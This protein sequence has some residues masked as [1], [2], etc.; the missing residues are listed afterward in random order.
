[1]FFKKGVPVKREEE[2][3]QFV[4]WKL[5]SF[6][7]KAIADKLSTEYY[8]KIKRNLNNITSLIVHFKEHKLNENNKE[9]P[10]KYS[11]HIRA[12]A[13]TKI[14][15]ASSFDWDLA[16]TLHK[17]YNELLHQTSRVMKTSD[18]RPKL[19]RPQNNRETRTGK[20]KPYRK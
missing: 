18:Q 7:E 13:P 15:E 17:V 6:Q 3:I 16:R 2:L 8:G 10:R 20:A 4:G 12:I 19:R 9:K 5:L 11:I 14:F 1:M